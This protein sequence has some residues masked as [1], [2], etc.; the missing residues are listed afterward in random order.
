MVALRQQ[1]HTDHRVYR[2]E[3]QVVKTDA[4]RRT[5]YGE[6][7]LAAPDFEDGA[8]LRESQIA[9]AVHY[10]DLFVDATAVRLLADRFASKRCSVDVEHKRKPIGATVVESFVAREG[11]TPWAAGSWVCGVQIHE[12]GVWQD[13]LDGKLTGFSIEFLVRLAPVKV[14]VVDDAGENEIARTLYRASDPE[15]MFLSLV[16]YPAS[17]AHWKQIARAVVPF[18]DLPLAEPETP[19][20]SAAARA[21]VRAWAGGDDLD[22][23]KY[24]K[25]FL[26]YD[27]AEPDLLGSYKFPIADVVDGKLVAVPRAIFAAAARL[28]QAD[29]PA[30]DLPTMRAVLGSY[31]EKMERPAPW[32]EPKERTMTKPATPHTESDRALGAT[33]VAA[34][35]SLIGAAPAT[36]AEPAPAEEPESDEEYVADAGLAAGTKRSAFEDALHAHEVKEDLC[37]AFWTLMDV[38]NAIGSNAGI[39]DKNAAM[40]SEIEA[41]GVWVQAFAA[42]GVEM[43]AVAASVTKTLALRTAAPAAETVARAGRRMAKHRFERFTSAV[44]TLNELHRELNDEADE[45]AA[46]EGEPPAKPE[47]IENAA[48]TKKDETCAAGDCPTC[49]GTGKVDGETCPDCGGTGKMKDEIAASAEAAALRAQLD[50][51]QAALAAAKAQAESIQS[52]HAEALRTVVAEKAARSDAEAKL[53]KAAAVPAAPA[54]RSMTEAAGSPPAP[55][56][57]TRDLARGL[58]GC[59]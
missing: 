2:R 28:D 25:A 53:A 4:D 49:K 12:A 8:V 47:D 16:G 51:V 6:V 22:A 55:K 31:Y 3:V 26:W 30:E 46:A 50:A 38:L 21:R 43:E 33:L 14:R 17:G 5:V 1:S 36:P 41:F 19:W 42:G 45:E 15:P 27:E 34:F 10:D 7:M 13:V 20:N 56:I 59:E 58:F 48:K 39:T 37:E 23:A 18:G 9:D 29:V 40:L 35:R 52:Q 54:A 44:G 11:W 57:T 32:D 24:R